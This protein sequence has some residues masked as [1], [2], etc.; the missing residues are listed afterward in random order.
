[1]KVV[2]FLG[3]PGAGKGTQ[4][5]LLKKNESALHIS[6]GDLIRGEISMKTELGLQ[7]KDIVESG[8]LLADDLLFKLLNAALSRLLEGDKP[9]LLI[10][11]G[12]PR[13]KEQVHQLD[14]SLKELNLKVDSVL[15]FEAE[16]Q[17]LV[18]RF[19]RR[20]TCSSCKAVSSFATE[21]E[22]RVATCGNCQTT[23]EFYRRK[24]DHPDNVK[25]RLKVYAQQTE[26]LIELYEP[27]QLLVRVNALQDVEKVAQEVKSKLLK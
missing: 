27:R 11:D 13:N 9:S 22:A 21:E 3:P 2:V 8:K 10:L 24:D 26:P 5:T 25:T 17:A 18:D 15:L 14:E 6:T 16:T 12:V 1:M 4:A 20:W 7:V 19:A 23:G